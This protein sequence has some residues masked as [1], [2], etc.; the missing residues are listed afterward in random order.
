MSE[1][2]SCPVCSKTECSCSDLLK[3]A[4]RIALD[5][6]NGGAFLIPI[7]DDRSKANASSGRTENSKDKLSGMV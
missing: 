3:R 5:L 6:E 4:A 7:Y 2:K 1:E